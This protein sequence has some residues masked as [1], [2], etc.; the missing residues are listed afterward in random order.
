M[1]ERDEFGAFL[2]GFI[3]GGLTGAV[4][5]LLFAPQ[6]GEET[7]ALIKDKSIELRDK[8]QVSAE[9]ALARAEQLAADARHRADEL[10][11]EARAR[12]TELAHEVRERGSSIASEVRTRG[13]EA[14]EA[15]RKPKKGDGEAT[16]A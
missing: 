4:V 3:V 2:V 8:A 10:T 1:S 9:E 15:V 11:K 14:I 5:A 12:A 6:S 7:R 16:A 13:K